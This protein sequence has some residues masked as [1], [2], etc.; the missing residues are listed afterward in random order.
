MDKKYLE[1]LC[2]ARDALCGFCEVDD[3]ENCIVTHLIDD[4]YNEMPD[5]NGESYTVIVYEKDC[6]VIADQAHYDNKEEA[7]SFAKIRDWDEVVDNN[8]SEIVWRK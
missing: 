2:N 4:A 8:S 1:K 5:E 3:C 7:I 6:L